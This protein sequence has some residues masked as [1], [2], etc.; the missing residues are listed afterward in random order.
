LLY[1]DK[2]VRIVKSRKD[3]RFIFDTWK[4]ITPQPAWV[5]VVFWCYLRLKVIIN[6]Q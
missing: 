2:P 1:V 3:I 6:S 4:K 5:L